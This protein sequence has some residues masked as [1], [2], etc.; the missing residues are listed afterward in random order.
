MTDFFL[1]RKREK[2]IGNSIRNDVRSAKE[3]HWYFFLNW[4]N[5]I[6]DGSCNWSP[7]MIMLESSEGEGRE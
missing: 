1:S 4:Q 2:K 3:N 7:I 5:C 6:K